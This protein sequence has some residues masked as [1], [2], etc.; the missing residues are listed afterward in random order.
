M[1]GRKYFAFSN[2]EQIGKKYIEKC[3]ETQA[4]WSHDIFGRNW[5]CYT[6][7]KTEKLPEKVKP[8]DVTR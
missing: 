1:A 8:I 5:A 3:D 2:Y 6:G 7:H 4:G